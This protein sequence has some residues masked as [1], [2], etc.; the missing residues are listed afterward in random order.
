MCIMIYPLLHHK[1]QFT[2]LTIPVFH[3]FLL[4][5]LTPNLCNHWS[6]NASIIL[7]F[8]KFHIV[9]IIQFLY[10]SDSLLSLR[11]M[12]L[13]FF[14]VFHGLIPHLFF[15]SLNSTPLHEN[16]TICLFV[17]WKIFWLL[18]ILTIINKATINI[19]MHVFVWT[20]IFS[21]FGKKLGAKLLGSKVKLCLSL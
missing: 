14:H 6:F 3:L 10:F 19:C 18:Q 1:E 15:L 20:Y 4:P 13:T 8:A 7:H 16:T 9:G 17:H 2:A 21:L 12:H 5:P 11:M